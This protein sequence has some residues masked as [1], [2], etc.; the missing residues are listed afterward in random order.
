MLFDGHLDRLFLAAGRHRGEHSEKHF[1]VRS[2]AQLGLPL[3]VR[4]TNQPAL[5]M[6]RADYLEKESKPKL[7]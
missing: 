5:T 4:V 7:Q 2:L 6:D 3:D 1:T